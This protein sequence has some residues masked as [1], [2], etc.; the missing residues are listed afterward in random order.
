MC[1]FNYHDQL[2]WYMLFLNF[3]FRIATNGFSRLNFQ[4]TDKIDGSMI[5]SC[6]KSSDSFHA[7]S[8]LRNTNVDTSEARIP[9]SSPLLI[10]MLTG[11]YFT[12]WVLDVPDSCQHCKNPLMLVIEW[13]FCLLKRVILQQWCQGVGWHS[14][15]NVTLE[16]YWKFCICAW[17][18][19]HYERH[20][21]TSRTSS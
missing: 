8:D 4:D 15:S 14:V 18:A 1:H 10:E 5:S 6:T 21:H 11:V 13:Q 17:Y 12:M 2:L 7:K 9:V 19:L 20:M 16:C 3:S